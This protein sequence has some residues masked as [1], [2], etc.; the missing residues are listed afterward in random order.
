MKEGQKLN[1]SHKPKLNIFDVILRFLSDFKK[2]LNWYY[3]IFYTIIINVVSFYNN[4]LFLKV[5]GVMLIVLIL[6]YIKS[7]LEYPKM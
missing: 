3:V 5:N 7:K 4:P 2:R 6:A 1:E